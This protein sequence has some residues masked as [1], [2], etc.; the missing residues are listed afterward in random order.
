MK[1]LFASK[2]IRLVLFSAF[3]LWFAWPPMPFTSLL[4][5][6]GLVPLLMVV[7]QI[8]GRT[9]LVKKGARVFGL[10]AI[11]FFLWN[12]ACTYWVFN[13]LAAVMPTWVAMLV[14]WLPFGTATLLMTVPFWIYYQLRKRWSK[15]IAYIGLVSFWISCE[16]LYQ[17]WDA[18]FPWM[19]LGNGFAQSHQLIQWY[20]YTGVYGGTFWVLVANILIF[21]SYLAFKKTVTNKQKMQ[22]VI[23]P[24]V[25]A[26][27]PMMISLISYLRYQE[28]IN[29]ASVIVVQPNVDPYLKYE[30]DPQLQTKQLITLSD[31]LAEAG[32]EYFIWPETAIPV[33]CNE[34]DFLKNPNYLLVR[35]F[36]QKYPHGNVISGLES[37]LLY[38]HE[39]TPTAQYDEQSGK[40]WDSFNAAV[41]IEDAEKV[42][43][44]HKS[45]L[46]PG[47]ETLPFA[48]TLSFLKPVF[49]NFGGTTG[50]YG[51]Q[52]EPSVFYAQSGVGVAPVICYESIWG[53]YVAEYVKKG[54][55]FIAIITN[56]GWWGN[57][58]GKDQHLAYAKLRAL[59]TRRWVARSANT[60]I[61]AFINQRGD[62]VKV[63]QWWVATALKENINLNEELT[64]YVK[65]GDYIA[66]FSVVA[67]FV[68]GLILLIGL[69]LKGNIV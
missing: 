41:Q 61:S 64:F 51:R 5:L 37:Y 58:S 44:Y 56:D 60:G 40:Y 22:S 48:S 19:N 6:I 49:A 20:E 39:K 16:Y 27:F 66:K 36:L 38:D 67:C 46:V 12:A 7:E 23:A 33:F 9:G 62:V 28:K 43:F 2:N 54:A 50:G 52:A 53:E 47:P 13:S 11:A 29:P 18:P 55:Q 15:W 69:Y 30:L 32:T 35:Q 4:L 59:E 42:Q 57:T 31:S 17:T 68:S 45:K 63:S 21:E 34:D 24:F 10:C 26:L 14:I 65:N 1:S 3:L 8:I 25:W